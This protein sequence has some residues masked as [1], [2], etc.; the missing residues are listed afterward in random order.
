[1]VIFD[2]MHK[3]MVEQRLIIDVIINFV[4]IRPVKIWAPL[5][6]LFAS[7]GVPTWLRA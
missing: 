5:R 3:P 6:K 1:M 2:A 7:P 4:I